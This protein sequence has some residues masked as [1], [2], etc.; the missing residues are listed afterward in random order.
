MDLLKKDQKLAL[1]FPKESKLVEIICT[2]SKL[3]DDRIELVLPQYFMRYIDHLQVGKKL[4]AKAFSK[5]GTVDF[6]TLIISSPLEDSFLI[7]LDYNAIKLNSADTIPKIISTEKLEINVDNEVI[8][9]KTLEIGSDYL[10]FYSDKKFV[11]EQSLSCN[12]FLPAD[13]GIINLRGIISEIDSVYDNEYTLRYSALAEDARQTI[14]Y[15]MYMYSKD[16]D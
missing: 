9:L 12:L 3:Y 7:E 4:T 15:Y 13:Y 1:I 5:F 10:K 14:L 16:F 8:T 11:L 6:N 2:I